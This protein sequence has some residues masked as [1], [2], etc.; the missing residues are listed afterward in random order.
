MGGLLLLSWLLYLV[1]ACGPAT[2]SPEDTVRAYIDHLARNRMD[3]AMMLCTPAQQ[4]YLQALAELMSSTEAPDD[5]SGVKV[6]GL[7][8]RLESDTAYCA[9][10]Q[11][12]AFETYEQHY[13]LVMI[14]GAW[15]VDYQAEND[16][17]ENSAPSD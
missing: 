2:P 13:R 8:C 9:S 7:V 14:D 10:R 6:L 5:T 11:R 4:A 17:R 3:E 15:R 16:Y 12:D 1:S